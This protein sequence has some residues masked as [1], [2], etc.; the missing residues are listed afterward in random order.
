MLTLRAKERIEMTDDQQAQLEENDTLE[1][2]PS[3]E[4]TTETEA[5]EEAGESESTSQDDGVGELP[6][7]TKPRTTEQFEKLK[8]QLAEKTARLSRYER[9]QAMGILPP[10]DKAGQDP[11][12]ALQQKVAYLES[13]VTG[14]VKQSEEQ[15]EQEAYASFPELNPKSGAFD[16]DF[17]E[18]VISYMATQFAKGQAP[19][20]K[21]AA[22]KLVAIAEK[23]AKRAEKEG[24]KK[25]LEQLSPKEQASLEATGRS[26]RRMPSVDFAD[27]RDKTRM[28]GLA[29]RDAAFERLQ[30]ISS[31]TK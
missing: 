21:E 9:Q 31:V 16:N 24:A 11:V 2:M 5:L 25:A 8:A 26:D 3:S 22:Q 10:Q 7:G 20:I 12:Q 28:G 15:Q 30:K 23:R 29:G 13:Q 27:L 19:T 1:P 6:E 18:Q 17:Q 14:Y 4:E